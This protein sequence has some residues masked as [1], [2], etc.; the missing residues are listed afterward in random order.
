[1]GISV[2][3]LPIPPVASPLAPLFIDAFKPSRD[4]TGTKKI[5]V[6]FTKDVLLRLRRTRAALRTAIVDHDT[7]GLAT[8]HMG[9]HPEENRLYA[10]E[11]WLKNALNYLEKDY[12]WSKY[13][14]HAWNDGVEKAFKQIEEVPLPVKSRV[15]IINWRVEQEM[16]GITGT[17]VQHVSRA[18]ETAI[19]DKIKPAMAWRRMVKV[20]DN[21]GETRF[22]AMA[23]H[24]II[25]AHNRAKLAAYR[26]LGMDKVGVIPEMH[27]A[28]AFRDADGDFGYIEEPMEVG[29][30]TA[31]DDKVCEDCE[32]YAAHGPYDIDD[33]EQALPLHVNCRCTWYPWSDRRFRRD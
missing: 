30:R 32:D 27:A 31:G 5:R 18:A 11:M 25:A 7:L 33:V 3:D 10:F 1:M 28:H 29:V 24:F 15:D 20:F 12:W 4:P 14:K 17:L 21:I 8:G 6:A 23:D 13:I 2:I 16:I 22:R 19:M 9:F 26:A